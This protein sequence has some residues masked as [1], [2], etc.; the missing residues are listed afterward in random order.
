MQRQ[1]QQDQD[2]V[3]WTPVALPLGTR[4]LDLRR[5]DDPG[6][7]SEL[8]NA[9]FLDDRTVKRRDGHL[10]YPIQSPPFAEN[11]GFPDTPFRVTDE[12]VYGH[13]NRVVSLTNDTGNA[14]Y[15]I[16]TR[17]G[18]TFRFEDSD[19]VFTGDRLM[20]ATPDGPF[21]GAEKV[22][23]WDGDGNRGV[24]AFLPVQTDEVHPEAITG[25]Y[26]DVTFTPLYRVVLASTA[27]EVI[28]WVYDRVTGFLILREAVDTVATTQLRIIN[29][30]GVP[31]A[32]WIT[33][34][35]DLKLR[36]Y[37]GLW[38]D[39]TVVQAGVNAFDVA[40][41]AAGFLVVWRAAA[42]V[43]IGS[44]TGHKANSTLFIF[45]TTV[46]TTGTTPN[47]AVTVTSDDDGFITVLWGSL[48]AGGHDQ[49]Y[50]RMF[51]SDMASAGTGSGPGGSVLLAVEDDHDPLTITATPRKLKTSLGRRGV[52]V[53]AS[54][55]ALG[56]NGTHSWEVTLYNSVLSAA[57]PV[58]RYNAAVASK[59]FSVG[60][61]VFCWL[62]SGNS[63]TTFLIAN[64]VMR[65][66][67]IADREESVVPPS[68]WVPSVAPDPN[69]GHTYH[70]IRKRNVGN[71]ARV[72]NARVGSLNFLNPLSTA[73]YGRSV[74][75]AG[76]LVRNWDGIA[77]GEAGFHDY[78]IV[79]SDAKDTTGGSMTPNA[80]YQV[81]VYPVRYNAK[82][83][84]FQGPAFTYSLT[85]GAAQVK[86]TLNIRTMPA[87]SQTDIEYEVYR[88]KAG[89]GAFYYEGKVTHVLTFAVSFAC[90]LSDAALGLN[91][92]D[93]FETGVGGKNEIDEFGPVGCAK[94]IT[95]ADRLWGFGGQ[96]PRG[97]VHFSKL[98]SPNE[99]ASFDSLSTSAMQVMD[100]QGGEITSLASFN[101]ATIVAFQRDRFYILVGGGP[102]NYGVG[103]FGVPQMRS[104]DGA[105]AHE[106]TIVTPVGIA[107]WGSGG[108][109]ILTPNLTVENISEPVAEL[110]TTFVP[111]GVRVDFSRREVIWHSKGGDALLWNYSN[112][113]RWARWTGLPIAGCSQTALVTVDG[114]YLVQTEGVDNDDG[115]RFT[116]K[117]ATGNV[118]P[119]GLLGGSTL[120]RRFGLVGEY[121]AAHRARFRIYY[122]NSPLWSQTVTWVPETATWHVQGE[123]VQTLTPA[124]IDAL[125][126]VDKAGSYATHHRAKRQHCQFFRL[127]VSDLGQEGFIPWE[128]V[129]ELGSKPGLSRTPVNTFES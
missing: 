105:L 110:A 49:V 61:A 83:E 127:E 116:F 16:H 18:G 25:S 117:L 21:F 75:L 78:P 122:D 52:A 20:V 86:T 98:Y 27:T 118:R 73:H 109:R 71:Y 79:I 50:G 5:A 84:R 125:S 60:N 124:Q 68:L 69:D 1:S 62:R 77:L 19:V 119:E 34:G 123:D 31:V 43:K 66:C 37:Y 129:F 100:T 99:G 64:T 63:S 107:Y 102:D 23:P 11:Y 101:D 128:F 22:N 10:G 58:V 57:P 40:A 67:A 24:Q 36:Y 89:G 35:G 26:V 53:Y 32:L 114:R 81:R 104:A 126:N 42:V 55:S 4:G 7:L 48:N 112:G 15:P 76:S 106:G 91:T 46:P 6:T 92:A 39:P 88:T 70:W 28:A 87:T 56:V 120:L 90:T 72:G 97:A 30:G 29:S 13:G 44:Y 121:L 74:Y 38:S 47:A 14:Y 45:G 2:G 111:S 82:G 103:A 108:P 115:R 51:T 9:R 96:V 59:A 113:S 54:A 41:T 93:P 80:L 33:S 17:G 3:V 95:A 65:M 85:M 94:L 12:W 8:L